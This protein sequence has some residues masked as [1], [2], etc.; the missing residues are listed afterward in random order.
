[1]EADGFGLPGFW[2]Q[3]SKGPK[4]FTYKG[5]PNPHSYGLGG[6]AEYLE[7]QGT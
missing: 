6:L 2:A 7:D 1:M 3:G 5:P 4:S